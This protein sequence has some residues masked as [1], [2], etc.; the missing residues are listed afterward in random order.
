[1]ELL[2]LELGSSKRVECD[3]FCIWLFVDHL[4]LELWSFEKGWVQN[5]LHLA[6]SEFLRI[7]QSKNAFSLQLSTSKVEGQM[8][9]FYVQPSTFN[10]F[11]RINWGK[12]AFSLQLS[13]SKVEGQVSFFHAQPRTFS[14]ESWRPSELFLCSTS[15]GSPNN[16]LKSS[17][18]GQCNFV[19]STSH[20]THELQT[21]G[22]HKTLN[23][24]ICFLN[25]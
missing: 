23:T 13:T 4:S 11:L 1:V 18:K 12:N 14:T 21:Q 10:A 15:Y 5:I 17:M 19:C 25:L 20:G 16:L 9:C 24:K 8:N 22:L 7:G 3:L 6:F 2:N